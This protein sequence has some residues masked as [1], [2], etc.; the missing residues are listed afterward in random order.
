M[1]TP[2]TWRL[3]CVGLSVLA[4][5]GACSSFKNGGNGSPDAG[6]ESGSGGGGSSGGSSGSGGSGGRSGGGELQRRKLTAAGGSSAGDI[7]W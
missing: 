7:E 1:V 2:K 4:A 3:L 6:T 5:D